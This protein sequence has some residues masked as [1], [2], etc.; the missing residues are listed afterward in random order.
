MVGAGEAAAAQAAG[1]HA[2]IPAILLNHDVG[3]DFGGPEERVLGLVDGKVFGD[4][5]GIGGVGVVP[6][7][8]QLGQ[9]NSIGPVAI[10]LVGGHVDEGGFR[11]GLAGGFQ[12]VQGADGIGVEVIEGDGGGAVVGGLGGGVD[13]GIGLEGFQQ[14]KHAGTIP[15]VEFMVSERFPKGFGEPALVPSGIAL[16]AEE[17]GSLVVI[18]AMDVPAEFGKVNA[19]F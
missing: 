14:F 19:N 9:S 12:Q 11:A 6:A 17:D 10:D 4:P 15:D 7:G 18:H 3:R 8:V 1:G 13:D 16:W 2:K 5:I